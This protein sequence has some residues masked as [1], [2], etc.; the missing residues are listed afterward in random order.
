MVQKPVAPSAIRGGCLK[1]LYQRNGMSPHPNP[2]RLNLDE[3]AT[4]RRRLCP[5]DQ[6]MARKAGFDGVESTGPNGYLLDQF[7]KTSSN[8]RE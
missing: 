8:K 6:K 5:T 3:N 4:H 7:L 2:V 1:N